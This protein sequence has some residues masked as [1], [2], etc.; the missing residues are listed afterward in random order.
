M[1]KYNK[2]LKEFKA[3]LLKLLL[4]E[5]AYHKKMNKKKRLLLV[6]NFMF[7]LCIIYIFFIEMDN[8]EILYENEKTLSFFFYL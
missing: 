1:K 8:D 2:E 4:L 6:F 3:V 7:K 5:I